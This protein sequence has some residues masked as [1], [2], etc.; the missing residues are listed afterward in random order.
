M[1]RRNIIVACFLVGA[2]I[3]VGCKIEAKPIVT[4]HQ[5]AELGDL[6]SVRWHIR[7][8]A[9]P[10]GRDSLGGGTPL[11]YA[12][13]H[14]GNI[15]VIE[16]L[17]KSGANLLVM[18]RDGST[19][20]HHAIIGDSDVAT[21]EWLIKHGVDVNARDDVGT[22]ALSLLDMQD[23]PNKVEITSLLQKYGGVR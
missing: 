13:Q 3:S 22:S 18:D 23:P 8:G 15:R 4:L 5:A 17:V 12:V 16:Y 11:Q 6:V 10:N 21:I 19:L 9:D 1:R 14:E 20:L 7:H 2:S